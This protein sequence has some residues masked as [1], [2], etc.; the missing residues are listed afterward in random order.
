MDKSIYNLVLNTSTLPNGVALGKNDK[1][2]VSVNDRNQKST[3]VNLFKMVEFVLSNSGIKPKD[4]G[5][6]TLT[7]GPGSFTG[8]RVAIAFAKGFCYAHKIPISA[9]S[10]I[11][12]IALSHRLREGLIFPIVPARKNEYFGALFRYRDGMCERLTQDGVYSI[13]EIEKLPEPI[14]IIASDYRVLEGLSSRKIIVVSSIVESMVE[15]GYKYFTEGKIID[16]K[17]IKPLYI[18][19]SDAE[20]ARGIKIT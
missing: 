2:L 18:K 19:G 8:I 16:I 14:E 4:I 10:T 5:L 12:A 9:I 7:V 13:K 3:S 1:V 11:E 20:E 6:L 17:T 15:V